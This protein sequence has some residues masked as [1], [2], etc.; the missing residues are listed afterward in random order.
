MT[1]KWSLVSSSATS[2]QP[3]INQTFTSTGVLLVHLTAS[4][5]VSNITF[6]F[7]L[8]V[9]EKLSGLYLISPTPY[10]DQSA[11][12]VNKKASFLFRLTS[13]NGYTC[14]LNFGDGSTPTIFNDSS[15]NL[16]NTLISHLY[17]QESTFKL[18]LTCT[19]SFNSAS[20][21]LD[22]YVQFELSNLR[23]LS[24]GAFRLVPFRIQFGLDSGSS[25]QTSL[26]VNSRLDRMVSYDPMTKIGFSSWRVG[27]SSGVLEVNI[28]ALN[29][30]SSLSCSG[31]FEIGAPIS[32]PSL[33]LSD[34]FFSRFMYN[35]GSDVG[36]SV[37]MLEGSNVKLE[38]YFGEGLTKNVS[39]F[40]GDW[41]GAFNLSYKHNNP[42][43]YRIT[44]V[45]SNAFGRFELSQEISVVSE[46]YGLIP[47]LDKNPV[48]YTVKG[49]EAS[50][51]FSFYGDTKA[52]SHSSVTFWP[53]DVFNASMGPF[54]LGMDFGRNQSMNQLGFNY[55]KPGSY[56]V[57]FLVEN[58]RGSRAFGLGFEVREGVNGLNLKV[59]TNVRTRAVF[60][61]E[62]FLVQG[63][64][65]TFVWDFNSTIQI[66]NCS[67]NYKTFLIDFNILVISYYLL[68]YAN[69]KN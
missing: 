47:R 58:V 6:S 9:V 3:S 32:S 36:C 14:Q 33:T 17:T 56:F 2:T 41:S 62:T 10:T 42:G 51:L 53:G 24:F 25:P 37:S 19:N 26:Y 28:T 5:L 55:D 4:N 13:G 64:W 12:I 50:F 16:N 49:A 34:N 39:L 1:Y 23:L 66:R 20:Y 61:V 18:S 52:G 57:A 31:L 69:N 65:A 46:V 59:P 40:Y 54:L 11:S 30:V 67:G 48:A 15:S 44:A 60:G 22:H 43:D 68:D 38:V 29:L 35:F 27:S 7:N 45:F 21:E 63:K 8:T